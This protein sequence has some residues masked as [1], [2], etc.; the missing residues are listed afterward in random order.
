[1]ADHRRS[2]SKGHNYPQL[3]ADKEEQTPHK[4]GGAANLLTEDHESD[5]VTTSS[6]KEPQILLPQNSAMSE[7]REVCVCVHGKSM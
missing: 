5:W 3:K 6:G 7:R 4:G 2:R 1:M